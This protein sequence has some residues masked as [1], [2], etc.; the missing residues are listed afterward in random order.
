METE[1]IALGQPERDRL[2]V[3]LDVQQGRFTQVAAAQRIQITDLCSAK[4]P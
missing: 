2:H 4:S 3:L 1:R